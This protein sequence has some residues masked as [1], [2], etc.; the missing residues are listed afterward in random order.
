M[1]G[2]I[3]RK[4]DTQ[5]ELTYAAI[6]VRTRRRGRDKGYPSCLKRTKQLRGMGSLRRVVEAVG[7]LTN[8]HFSWLRETASLRVRPTQVISWNLHPAY[9]TLPRRAVDCL[10]V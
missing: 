6:P 9:M 8:Q 4:V 3:V 2:N 10:R 7:E 5:A 1:R